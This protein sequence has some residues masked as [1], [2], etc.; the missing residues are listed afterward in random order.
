MLFPKFSLGS[1]FLM[2][3]NLGSALAQTASVTKTIT[4]QLDKRYGLHLHNNT[5]TVNLGSTGTAPG[6]SVAT[7]NCYRA[8][9]HDKT[10]GRDVLY[11]VGVNP[12]FLNLFNFAQFSGDTLKDSNNPYSQTVNLKWYKNFAQTLEETRI[13]PVSSYP[14]FEVVAGALQWK[15]PIMCV[16]NTTLEVFSNQQRFRDGAPASA[17]YASLSTMTTN[18]PKMVINVSNAVTPGANAA[19]MV[20]N[21]APGVRLAT[22][23]N[24]VRWADFSV[25]QALVFDGSETAASSGTAT[26]AFTLAD[27]TPIP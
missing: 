14:G 6:S 15:G 18:F 22:R 26:L 11:G 23:F 7:S 1:L 25:I 13:V 9:E 20:P 8:G 2:C 5:W 16:L 3:L 24:P 4:I 21:A 27:F 19:F 12:S 17:V 10:T